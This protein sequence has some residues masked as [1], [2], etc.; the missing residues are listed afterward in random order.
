MWTHELYVSERKSVEKNVVYNQMETVCV[1]QSTAPTWI[2]NIPYAL[3]LSNTRATHVSVCCSETTCTKTFSDEGTYQREK[4]IYELDLPYV[5]RLV[6]YDNR[7]R[8]ITMERA[9]TPLGTQMDILFKRNHPRSND[10]QEL[11]Q[12]FTQDTGLYHNDIGYRNVL[13]D[14][15]GNLYLID[16]EHAGVKNIERD[17]DRILSNT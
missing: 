8:S 12:K 2:K 11:N 7:S 10:I 3:G 17:S 4:G 16:F 9:G 5:P 1:K 6:S 14:T 15:S 13:E